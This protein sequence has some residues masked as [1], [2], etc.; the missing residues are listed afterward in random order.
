MKIKLQLKLQDKIPL[1]YSSKNEVQFELDLIV[2][3]MVPYSR[4]HHGFGLD[5]RSDEG[6]NN[7]N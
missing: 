2:P 4:S 7:F 3:Y 5:N 1:S 6:Q